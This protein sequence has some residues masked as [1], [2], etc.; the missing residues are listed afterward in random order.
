MVRK[1][2]NLRNECSLGLGATA[3]SLLSLV[4]VHPEEDMHISGGAAAL[5]LQQVRGLLHEALAPE[6][7]AQVL[8]LVELL[9]KLIALLQQAHQSEK[10]MTGDLA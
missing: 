8:V 9:G 7:H 3:L 2:I 10:L 6:L 5:L 4:V 1:E